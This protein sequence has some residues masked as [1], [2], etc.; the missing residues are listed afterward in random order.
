MTLDSEKRAAVIREIHAVT[1]A[2][3]A[4][5]Y[6]TALDH[7]NKARD[8]LHQAILDGQRQKEGDR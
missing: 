5:K 3:D 6:G 4:R 2:L 7:A 1:E 8:L